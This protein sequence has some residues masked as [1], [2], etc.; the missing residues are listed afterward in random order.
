MVVTLNVIWTA[1]SIGQRFDV[2]F[3]GFDQHLMFWK[4]TFVT[5]RQYLDWL[6]TEG[7]CNG[8]STDLKTSAGCPVPPTF[9]RTP[10]VSNLRRMPS[11]TDLR[12]FR[13]SAKSLSS[14]LLS[15]PLSVAAEAP[16]IA[17]ELDCPAPDDGVLDLIVGKTIFVKFQ[18]HIVFCVGVLGVFVCFSGADCIF[19]DFTFSFATGGARRKIQN[20]KK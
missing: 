19:Y 14:S 7:S 1:F 8:C 4:S 3:H 12:S 6:A 15:L 16:T 9:C 11:V 13:A 20:R 5:S 2:D 17:L 18:A 10:C